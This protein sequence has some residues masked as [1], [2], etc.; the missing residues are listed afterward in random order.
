[1]LASFRSSTIRSAYHIDIVAALLLLQ[2]ENR[3]PKT[4]DSPRIL[5]ESR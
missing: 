5:H 2:P 1:M 3:S 4:R